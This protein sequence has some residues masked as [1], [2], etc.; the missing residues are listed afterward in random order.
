[1]DED[2]DW[3]EGTTGANSTVVVSN[4]TGSA[5]NNISSAVGNG[6]V[7]TDVLNNISAS[8]VG[9]EANSS[10]IT[11][12]IRNAT[13]AGV[14]RGSKGDLS[15]KIVDILGSDPSNWSKPTDILGLI[16]VVA[17]FAMCCYPVMICRALRG[18][19]HTDEPENTSYLLG[20]LRTKKAAHVKTTNLLQNA[21]SLH[22][23]TRNEA[24]P[25]LRN[26]IIEQTTAVSVTYNLTRH[27]TERVG[28]MRWTFKKLRDKTIF[29]EE[30][31]WLPTRA[32]VVQMVQGIVTV[33]FPIVFGALTSEI[34]SAVGHSREKLEEALVD[35]EAYEAVSG[36]QVPDWVLR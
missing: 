33:A 31:I 17:V 5:F 30:G 32:F 11:D 4:A 35:L 20:E 21:L 29:D 28:G 1:M 7:V 10:N 26:S 14:F 25:S 2:P 3:N 8:I 15:D 34:G 12:L 19:K 9:V 22:S 6:T 24:S 23:T 16:V 18:M 13:G 27:E 36:I